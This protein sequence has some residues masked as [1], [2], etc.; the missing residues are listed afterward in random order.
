MEALLETSIGAHRA[1]LAPGL[2][3]APAYLDLAAQRELLGEVERAL[4]F[5]PFYRPRMPRSG[6]PFS[7]Q[8]TNFGRLGWVSDKDG[9]YRYQTFHPETRAPWAP[10]PALALRAWSALGAWPHPPEACLVNF[11]DASARLGLHQD[12]EEEDFSAPVVS[13]SLGDSCVFRFGGTSRRDP[14]R[15]IMLHSGDALVLGGASRLCF[16]GV[17]RI[18]PG[19]SCLLPD[20]GRINLTLRRVTRPEAGV[21]PQG[22]KQTP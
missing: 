11:Y 18:L 7:V 20:G 16:H 1:E 8:M 14:T 15:K 2:I 12:H 22:L 10:I 9:G 21:E 4:V 17:D 6:R 3:H 13:L 19:T 5:G